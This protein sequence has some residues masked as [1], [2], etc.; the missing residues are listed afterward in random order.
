MKIANSIIGVSIA[1]ILTIGVLFKTMHWPGGGV[2]II[3][4]TT[5]LSL[6]TLFAILF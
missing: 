3:F 5:L 2:M 6:Y 1:S 4:S